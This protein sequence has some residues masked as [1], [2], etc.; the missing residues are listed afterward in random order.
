[1]K[2][3]IILLSINVINII[4][5]K[6]IINYQDEIRGETE[7]YPSKYVL[8]QKK[9]HLIRSKKSASNTTP[10]QLPN[11]KSNT[12]DNSDIFQNDETYTAEKLAEERRGVSITKDSIHCLRMLPN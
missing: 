4:N 10:D 8:R 2:I 1:M 11:F 12:I 6:T 9:L 5:A 3:A 7:K